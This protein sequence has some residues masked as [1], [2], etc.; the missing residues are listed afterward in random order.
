MNNVILFHFGC[1]T[2]LCRTFQDTSEYSK[3]HKF[4]GHHP[5]P[6]TSKKAFYYGFQRSSSRR[7]TLDLSLTSRGR[8]WCNASKIIWRRNIFWCHF[9]PSPFSLDMNWTTPWNSP[10]KR[11]P[12]CPYHIMYDTYLIHLRKVCKRFKFPVFAGFWYRK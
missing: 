4:K 5:I 12:T 1:M 9:R 8:I 7:K 10:K 2:N 3:K 11:F 6:R